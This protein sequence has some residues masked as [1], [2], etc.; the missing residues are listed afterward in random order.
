M[1]QN[2][3]VTFI[4]ILGF[5]E[6]VLKE[7]PVRI[8]KIL[9]LVEYLSGSK[10]DKHEYS[11]FVFCFS[12][13]IIRVRQIDSP[14]N[15]EYPVGIL[16]HELLSLLHIQGELAHF[17]VLVR[18]GVSIGNVSVSENKVFGPAFID[19]YEIESKY[20]QYPRISLSTNVLR[21]LDDCKLLIAHDHTIDEEKSYIRNLLR[22][23][24]D[25]IWFID[26]L[27]AFEREVDAPELY[28][29]FLV[30]HKNNIL[31]FAHNSDESISRKGI[32]YTWLAQY[33]NKRVDEL[34]DEWLEHYQVK[35]EK[36][37][38]L[39][40]DFPALYYL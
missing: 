33:Q 22:L 40:E 14:A 39:P 28:Y 36:L 7:K 30:K 11:P 24:E 17:G 19:A 34:P 1:Y 37:K 4:D 15:K 23:A 12:D 9:N 5:R 38:V 13:S 3:I 29:Q 26:Y 8:L 6:L 2:S 16:F 31:K 20:A 18:G 27:Y 32:K 35:R 21:S 25:G 10:D